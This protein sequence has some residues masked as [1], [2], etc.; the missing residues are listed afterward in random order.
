M[1]GLK[2][3]V[4]R[5]GEE[6][7]DRIALFMGMMLYVGFMNVVVFILWFLQKIRNSK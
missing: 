2:Q 5:G 3:R 1:S 7:A 4:L 6:N